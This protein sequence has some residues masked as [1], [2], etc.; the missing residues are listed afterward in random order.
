M[1]AIRWSFFILICWFLS[2]AQ[3][4]VAAKYTVLEGGIVDGGTVSGR[5]LLDGSPPPP[6]MLK[7]DEDVEA[8]GGDDRP[9]EELLVNGNGGVKNVV[10]SIKGIASGKQWET[11]A[12]FV[13]DQRK[14][15]F[16]PRMLL[17]K[18]KIWCMWLQLTVIGLW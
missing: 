16:V 6:R 11:T 13:Y 7:V 4:A 2:A 15:K 5:I 8:C 12:D 14:C 10:L 17:I 3:P 18:P 1:S 9:S